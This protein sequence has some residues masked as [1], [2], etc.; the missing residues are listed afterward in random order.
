MR[1]LNY[2]LPLFLL[3]FAAQAAETITLPVKQTDNPHEP[4]LL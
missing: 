2:I 4:A 3:A 1:I